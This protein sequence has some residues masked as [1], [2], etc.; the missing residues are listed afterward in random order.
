M[1]A[2]NLKLIFIFLSIFA[3]KQA[4]FTQSISEATIRE[5]STTLLQL[6][7][8]S[9]LPE[10]PQIG[11]AQHNMANSHGKKPSF[12][13]VYSNIEYDQPVSFPF[14][15]QFN[16]SGLDYRNH[17][18]KR[19]YN[20]SGKA[21]KM[22]TEKGDKKVIVTGNARNPNQVEFTNGTDE[23]V[24][25]AIYRDYWKLAIV[26]K[27]PP[28]KTGSFEFNTTL[29]IGMIPDFDTRSLVTSKEMDLMKTEINLEGVKSGDIV[30]RGGGDEPF[31][32]SFENVIRK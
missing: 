21:L 1:E 6:I 11:I 29:L 10:L 32:I 3:S 16:F 18:T 25:G 24:S 31:T 20:V 4:S 12:W 7:N 14:T 19:V 15:T 30:V 13:R 28:G 5:D 8:Q 9:N 22:I 27:I 23:K 2:L 26:G 17:G